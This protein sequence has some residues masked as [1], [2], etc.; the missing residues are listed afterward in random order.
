MS[1]GAKPRHQQKRNVSQKKVANDA[2]AVEACQEEIG[3]LREQV[4]SQ[5]QGLL[6]KNQ[7]LQAI[8]EELKFTNQELYTINREL[9]AALSSECITLSKA[10]EL[11]KTLLV[12][13]Q[14][15]RESLAQLLSSI[16][17]IR[18]DP[19]ELG[20]KTTDESV[21]FSR[22][23]KENQFSSE[24]GEVQIRFH[25]LGAR[26]VA[27]KAQFNRFKALYEERTV[28]NNSLLDT[29]E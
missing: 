25:E 28:S 15:L 23:A 17:G 6:Y 3:V 8:E 12:S 24:Y 16:Y 29:E 4:E 21:S 26:Y 11:A 5:Q 27:F 7:Q 1:D 9:N 10:K 14:P 20:T 18:V 22:G 13:E 19:H 2:D